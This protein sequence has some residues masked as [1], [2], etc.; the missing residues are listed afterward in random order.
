MANK[1]NFSLTVI[2]IVFAIITIFVGYFLGNWMIRMAFENPEQSNEISKQEVNQ[3][4]EKKEVNI[5]E[6]TDTV[7]TIKDQNGKVTTDT[8]SKASYAV[9]VGAF[10]NYNNAQK[11]KKELENQ[12]YEVLITEGKPHKV[13]VG[14]SSE[15]KGAE[16]IKKEI[17]KIGYN[18]FVLNINN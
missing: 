5:D 6:K 10:N 3:E 18:G 14:P 15:K 17:E 13:R 9:Q 11:L 16:T 8:F 1:N 4:E 2:V 12:G 7:T